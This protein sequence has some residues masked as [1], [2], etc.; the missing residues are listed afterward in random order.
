MT[1]VWGPLGW[2]TL[3]SVATSYS[4]AP[5]ESEKQLM[6]SWLDLFRDTITCPSCRDHFTSLLANYRGQFP[7]MLNSRNDFTI[8]SFRAHNDVNRRL[9]K[10]IY[11][12]VTDCMATLLKNVENRTAQQYRMTYLDHI[13]RHFR[14]LRDAAG[15]AGL[16]KIQE[17]YKVE[18]EYIAPRDTK[19]QVT[20]FE[21]NTVLASAVLNRDPSE[22]IPR[23]TIP[24]SAQIGRFSL[25]GGGF[26]IRR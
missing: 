10:P 17:M 15:I 3:H 11:G 14:T 5:A 2:M 1:A 16:R 4:E 22:N 6:R 12:S 26:R 23:N 9:H 25:T 21:T 19:F 24:N 13:S 20:I 8:F 18:R 7:N